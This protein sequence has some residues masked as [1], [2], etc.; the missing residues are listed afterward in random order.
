[1]L[2]VFRST[3]LLVILL[4]LSSDGGVAQEAPAERDLPSLFDEVVHTMVRVQVRSSIGTGWLLQ[5]SG[6][7]LVVTNRHVVRPGQVH[8]VHF[9]QGTS[10]AP[11]VI[12]ART[13]RVSD[14][15]DLA[16]LRLDEDP[17]A[18][19]RAHALRVNTTIRRGDRVVLG[20]N[21]G[22]LP[23]QTTS[24]VVTGHVAG[25]AYQPCGQ[26]RNCVVV[27]AASLGGS[28]GGPALNMRGEL[29]GMLWG[30]PDQSVR[31]GRIAVG[32]H[33]QNPSLSYLIHTRTLAAELRR[34]E[35]APPTRP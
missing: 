21:P 9:Y 13:V 8:R 3:S 19:A 5:Q 32:A 29:V 27:D 31:V 22:S 28:S 2:A 18:S 7:P 20:G 10:N 30:G 15:I 17:P 12:T 4:V 14:Q 34:Y 23:F 24:G 35:R 26:G 1:M 25:E 33:V 11:V 16:L 6:R